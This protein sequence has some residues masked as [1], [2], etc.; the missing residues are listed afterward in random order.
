MATEITMPKL[1][2]TM[3]EGHL[4]AWRKS[5]GEKIERGDIIAEV[6][7]DKA[8]MDLEAFASGILLEQRVQ[9]GE[10]VPVGT[11]IGLIGL[12]DELKPAAS[13]I[14]E[15]NAPAAMPEIPVE[16]PLAAISFPAAQKQFEHS[17]TVQAAPIVRHRAAELGINLADV[18]GSGPEGRILLDDLERLSKNGPIEDKQVV[19]AAA[20][21]TEKILPATTA[22]N[23]TSEPL[24]RMRNAI[25]RVT[26][27]SWRTIPH[28]YISIEVEMERAEKVVR[29]LKAEGVAV[30]LNALILAAAAASLVKYP[31]LNA[32]LSD[33]GLL[34][35]ASINLGFAVA[36]EGGLIVPVIKGAENKGARELNDEAARL[37]AMSRAGRISA[38]E[39]SGGTFSVSNLGMHGVSSFASII[40][41]GQAGILAV[42][43]VTDRPVARNGSLEIGRFMT[44]TL[45]CDHRIIDGV[46]AA[47]FLKELKR[48]LEN[49]SELPA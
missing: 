44:A 8:T 28:F 24:S 41:P 42:G 19:I 23:I 30:S 3:T 18:T 32:T 47:D 25:A 4:G 15:V 13:P 11:V 45:S 48:L 38:D 43:T 9:A 34:K 16:P 46:Y 33:K 7:T 40:M 49:P 35:Y 12:P 6:E 2:D 31:G 21:S 29:S 5:V 17:T 26:T 20:E 22:R 37:A 14:V 36:V 39:I 1:S 10:L 27:D